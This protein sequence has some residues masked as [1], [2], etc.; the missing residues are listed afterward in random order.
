MEADAM[1]LAK[2]MTRQGAASLAAGMGLVIAGCGSGEPAA[3]R[4]LNANRPNLQRVD[5]S[6]D[7]LAASRAKT[8]ADSDGDTVGN[9]IAQ[10]TQRDVD[11]ILNAPKT[12]PG[13]ATADAEPQGLPSAPPLSLVADAPAAPTSNTGRTIHWNDSKSAKVAAANPTPTDSPTH[14]PEERRV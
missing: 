14:R 12:R 6:L 11:A 5:A 2:L 7:T 13:V 8:G 4:A 1:V 10:Q 9:A 3:L